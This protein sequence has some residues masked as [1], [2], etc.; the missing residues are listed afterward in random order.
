VRK[1]G[2]NTF[3]FPTGAGG[4]YRSIA[5]ATAP[6]NAADQFTAQYFKAGQAY[7]DKTKWDPSF[8]TVSGCE[9]W[10]LDRTTGTS[11]V[12]VSLSWNSAICTGSY[13][14][15]P[16]TL[17]VARWSGTSWVN[18]GNGGTTGNSS[19]G[20]VVTS[21]AVTSFSPFT[22]ASTTG[23]N[24]LPVTLE[25]FWAV[26]NGSTVALNWT[27]VSEANSDKFTLQ[28]SSNGFDF[29][30]IYTVK[31]AGNS[32]ERLQYTHTDDGPFGGLSYYR[33]IQTDYDGQ[34]QSWIASV[35]REGEDLPFNVSPNPVGE[36]V[37]KFSQRASIVVLNNLGQV[38]ATQHDV[39]SF[40]AATLTPGVYVIRNQKGQI[41]RLVRK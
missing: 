14:T 29:E 4:F 21:A 35:R 39:A 32:L 18:H 11:N 36:E 24:P 3:V 12:S 19:A 6:T 34:S 38:V 1:T 13:I 28:R 8:Y 20:T 2:T 26:D 17:R 37:V 27:T 31:A 23:A 40:N 41:V 10:I 30:T 9:Y 22:L 33:L 7:G 15:N 25:R 5:L 16:A